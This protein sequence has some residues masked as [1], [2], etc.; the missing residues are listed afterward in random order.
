M[1]LELIPGAKPVHAKPYPVPRTQREVFQKELTRL[2]KLGVLTRVGGT[3]WASPSFIIPRKDKTVRWVSGF[4][5]L[6]K[7]ICRKIFPIPL[8]Q[9]I[10]NKQSGY[11]YFTKIDISMQYYTFELTEDAKELCVIITPFGK[12]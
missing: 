2:V 4:Q 8:I 7:L 3:E 1:D 11:K 10:L 12:Y 5:E 9:E 6:N